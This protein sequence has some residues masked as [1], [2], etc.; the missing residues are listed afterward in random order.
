VDEQPVQAAVD[1]QQQRLQLL[2][3][4]EAAE[5]AAAAA[6]AAEQ[7]PRAAE[8]PP[9]EEVNPQQQQQ[10]QE[11]QDEADAAIGQQ[12][13]P[14]LEEELT[15]EVASRQQQQQR[16]DGL[17]PTGVPSGADSMRSD[18]TQLEEPAASSGQQ[19]TATAAARDES[20]QLSSGGSSSSSSSPD[21]QST[22]P[23]AQDSAAS[24]RQHA[25]PAA[26]DTAMF[27]FDTAGAD[28]VRAGMQEKQAL[29]RAKMDEQHG[30]NAAVPAAPRFSPPVEAEDD[31]GDEA[32]GGAGAG[33]L[34]GL[35]TSF[36][37]KIRLGAGPLM[38]AAADLPPPE[39][40][41]PPFKLELRPLEG[42]EHFFDEPY[43]DYYFDGSS[44]DLL[45]LLDGD[46]GGEQGVGDGG[47]KPAHVRPGVAPKSPDG[48]VG[49][50][51]VGELY[52]PY[53]DDP[54]D[55]T[56]ELDYEAAE[57][58]LL[59]G[60]EDGVDSRD[61]LQG[62]SLWVAGEGAVGGQQGVAGGGEQQQQMAGTAELR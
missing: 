40:E 20:E 36:R 5:A 42:A 4:Q 61:S 14:T 6:A 16:E 2:Q 11:Q 19:Q 33:G 56:D 17:D 10:Q 59:E 18:E 60:D 58:L 13:P 50:A 35:W 45:G 37:E 28:A 54:D 53:D 8:E 43:S 32:A 41:L 34:M 12:Q 23:A 25:T 1:E 22:Q 48:A 57:L 26:A 31:E 21:Q 29:V 62:G 49:G 15:E 24:Q 51:S 52:Q 55:N 39:G 27:H 9:T 44:E 38:A 46:L 30:R 47:G 3:Q 7:Q